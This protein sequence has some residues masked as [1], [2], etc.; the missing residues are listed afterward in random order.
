MT[1]TGSDSIVPEE[2]AIPKRWRID[3][4]VEQRQYLCDGKIKEWTGPQQN[5][6]SPPWERTQEG[7]RQKLIGSYPLLGEQQSLEALEAACR[8]YNHGRGAWPTTS[9]EEA[10]NAAIVLKA[11]IWIRLY[12]NVFSARSHTTVKDARLSK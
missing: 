10:K 7:I 6:F 12:G 4:L 11:R 1:G 8:A 5:V 2:S 3:S 9:V